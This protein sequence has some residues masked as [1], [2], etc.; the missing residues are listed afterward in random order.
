MEEIK[1]T[2]GYDDLNNLSYAL[3]LACIDCI[4]G[5]NGVLPDEYHLKMKEKLEDI[6]NKIQRKLGFE[7]FHFGNPDINKEESED[8]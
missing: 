1:M 7:E 4:G 2:F 6:L 8:K 5:D 3:Q